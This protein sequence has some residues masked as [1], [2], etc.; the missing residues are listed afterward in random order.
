MNELQADMNDSEEPMEED[1]EGEDADYSAA[2]CKAR[3]VLS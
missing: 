3:G 1:D 2:C